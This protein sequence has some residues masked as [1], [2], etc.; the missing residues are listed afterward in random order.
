MAYVYIIYWNDKK[1]YVSEDTFNDFIYNFGYEDDRK[2]FE[3]IELE[4]LDFF[5]HN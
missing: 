1:H 3:R 2:D 5:I 4:E